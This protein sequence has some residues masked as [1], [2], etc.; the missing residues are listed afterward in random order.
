MNPS[1]PASNDSNGMEIEDFP[2]QAEDADADKSG[3]LDQRQADVRA[4]N[5]SNS[6]VNTQSYIEKGRY[7]VFDPDEADDHLQ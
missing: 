7:G 3:L 6:K 2:T 1:G 5:R 4:S